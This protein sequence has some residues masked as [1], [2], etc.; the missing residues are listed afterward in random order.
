M[1]GTLGHKTDPK[2]A[3]SDDN[4]VEMVGHYVSAHVVTRGDQCLDGHIIDVVSDDLLPVGEQVVEN[5]LQ[6]VIIGR[7]PHKAPVVR[8]GFGVGV[9]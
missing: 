4:S 7:H 6:F 2:L 9:G 1:C 8:V 3:E 5:S